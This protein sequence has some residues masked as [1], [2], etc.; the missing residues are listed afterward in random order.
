MG[1]IR[2][3]GDRLPRQFQAMRKLAPRLAQIDW[4]VAPEQVC[5]VMIETAGLRSERVWSLVEAN[6]GRL[7]QEIRLIPMVTATLPATLL[8][9]L[10]RLT[11]VVKIW[12]NTQVKVLAG[13][14][15]LPVCG[16][17]W[18]GSDRYTGRGITVAVLDTGIAPHEDL[19]NP[20]N[21]ILAWHD[22]VGAQ[23]APYDDHGHGTHVAGLIAGNGQASRG[24]YL[25]VAPAARLAGVKVL[26]QSGSGRLS[27][28][29]LGIEW[30]LGNRDILQIRVMNLSLGTR[31][32]SNYSQDPLCRAAALAWRNGIVV[33]AAAGKVGLEFRNTDSPGGNERIITVGD[34]DY[35]KPLTTKDER[36]AQRRQSVGTNRNFCIPDLVAPGTN[37]VAVKRDGGYCTYSGT[38][39]AAPLVSGGTALLLERWPGLTPDQVK[40]LLKQKAANVGLGRQLHR[41][42]CN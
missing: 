25:G 15:A 30:C 26:D 22:L 7:D 41:L 40:R 35:Q 6:Q 4:K 16:G 36:L 38:S 3:G 14:T 10:V 2:I 32:Q 17:V 5:Q 27:D 20:E 29:I 23:T 37:V 13:E 31:S 11:P 34:L 12:E 1:Q 33:C 21:R 19:T 28:L 18:T 42:L 24:R 9:E 8:A 39:T